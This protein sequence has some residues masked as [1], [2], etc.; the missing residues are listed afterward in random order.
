MSESESTIE[1]KPQ[2]AGIARRLGA[3]VYDSMLVI[4]VLAVA[5]IPFLVLAPKKIIIPREVGWGMYLAYLCWQMIVIAAFFGFFWTRRGQTLGMQV[6]KLRVEDEQGKLL[7]WPSALRRLLFAAIPWLPAY[8]CLAVAEH[9]HSTTLKW[10]GE[11][12][13]LLVLANL[14]VLKFSLDQRSWHDRVSH[15]RVVRL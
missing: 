3:M 1:L 13:L 11:A 12:L 15:S 2:V 10:T 5:T 9:L 8:I 14:L 6:W 7:S 4:A